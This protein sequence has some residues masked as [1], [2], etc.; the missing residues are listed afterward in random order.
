MPYYLVTVRDQREIDLI[1]VRKR[2][3]YWTYNRFPTVYDA[4]VE[5]KG[6]LN[7]K[8]RIVECHRDKAGI[9]LS[10]RA[11]GLEVVE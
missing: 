11:A 5:C 9:A 6:I 8:F 3:A 10:M 1:D 7:P 4:L 2:S